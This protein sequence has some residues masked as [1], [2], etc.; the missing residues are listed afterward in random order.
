GARRAA[1]YAIF[2][3]HFYISLV[4]G[5]D[6][7]T[8]FSSEMLPDW[9]VRPIDLIW[10]FRSVNRYTLY[11]RIREARYLIEFR[12]SD[13]GGKTWR[14]YRHKYLPQDESHICPFIA[15]YF[16]RFEAALQIIALTEGKSS[17]VASVARRLLEG[18]PEVLSLFKDD[19]FNGHRPEAIRFT[20]YHY[21]FNPISEQRKT[22][23]YWTRTAEDEYLPPL[24]RDEG[25]GKVHFEGM[26]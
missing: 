4:L 18:S 26:N 12:G 20:T 3:V 24:I 17:V 22:G 7:I 9:M 21:V 8:P 15:P 5:L 16:P 2:G 6:T 11:W 1:L 14:P 23:K 13:D 10:N 25:T 19:P